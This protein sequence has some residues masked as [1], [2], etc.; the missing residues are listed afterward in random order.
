MSTATQAQPRSKGVRATVAS[1]LGTVSEWYAYGIYGTASALYIG[2][3][4]FSNSD[5]TTA[6]IAAFATFAVGYFARPLGGIILGQFGDRRGRKAMLMLTISIMAAAAFLVGCLPTYA[7]VGVWAPILLVLLRLIEGFGAGAELAGALTFVNESAPPRKRAFFTSFMGAASYTG[8]LLGTATFA[9]LNATLSSDQMLAWGWRVPFLLSGLI[10]IV[11]LVMRFR[12]SESEAFTVVSSE[13]VR[14]PVPILQLLRER[15]AAIAAGFLSQAVIGFS[16]FVVAVFALSYLT[17]TLGLPPQQGLISLIIA[18]CISIV[19]ALLFGR[20]AD[21]I[22][23]VRVL[24]LS[25]VLSALFAFPFFLLLN[26]KDPVLIVLAIAVGYSLTFGLTSGAQGVF[27]PSLFDTKYRLSGVAISR[28]L[29]NALLGGT[30]PLV[31]A[32]LVAALGGAPWLVASA[33]ILAGLLTLTGALVGV[34]L[35]RRRN[36]TAALVG[37]GG[38]SDDG[39]LGAPDRS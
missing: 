31:A 23:A 17:N 26:T 16:S 32:A 36:E 28:E 7:Q 39:E 33:M 9:I 6:T 21:R 24:I 2:P 8:I 13:V 34:P 35:L 10:V 18:G 1:A 3:L 38:S 5:P 37:T 15:K 29:A 12:I 25:G 22:G 27:L 20:L 4:F 19:A 11:P 14:Q 30:A